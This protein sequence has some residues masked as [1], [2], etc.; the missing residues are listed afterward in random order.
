MALEFGTRVFAGLWG[1]AGFSDERS[2]LYFL[3]ISSFLI[4]Y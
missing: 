2:E 4:S 3:T 1:E